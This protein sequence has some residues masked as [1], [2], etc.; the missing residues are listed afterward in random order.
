MLTSVSRRH[1]KCLI[2]DI[3]RTINVLFNLMRW[4]CIITLCLQDFIWLLLNPEI[5]FIVR[6]C[7][8][9]GR[10]IK[11]VMHL[12]PREITW[13]ICINC[14]SQMYFG[15]LVWEKIMLSRF[16]FTIRLPLMCFILLLWKKLLD[17]LFRVQ[18]LKRIWFKER[19]NSINIK[20]IFPKVNTHVFRLGRWLLL[21]SQ[22]LF[23]SRIILILL[24]WQLFFLTIALCKLCFWFSYGFKSSLCRLFI[25]DLVIIF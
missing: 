20:T 17:F 21:L 6:C 2:D 16:L 8:K 24:R 22:I 18:E 5:K 15:F 10:L 19:N 7:I 12:Y 25:D 9:L 3:I 23:G 14:F 11:L 4:G 13:S 1:I